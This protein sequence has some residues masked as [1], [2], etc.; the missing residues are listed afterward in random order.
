MRFVTFG[1]GKDTFIS[2]NSVSRIGG[3]VHINGWILLTRLLFAL[4]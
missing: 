3:S 2:N 4:F 1:M